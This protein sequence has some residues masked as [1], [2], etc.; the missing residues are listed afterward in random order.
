[1]EEAERIKGI[2]IFHAGTGYKKGKTI[3]QGGRVL[4]ITAIAPTVKEAQERAYEAIKKIDWPQ[5]FYRK[6]IGWR[7]VNK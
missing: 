7:A 1:M 6:D 2:T 4:N 3:A 5:G